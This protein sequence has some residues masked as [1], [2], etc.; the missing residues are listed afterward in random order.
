VPV[1]YDGAG[2]AAVCDLQKEGSGMIQVRRYGCCDKIFAGCQEPHC[3]TSKN[4][5]RDQREDVLA[6]HRIEMI[7]SKDFKLEECTCEYDENQLDLF[8][9]K[10]T[11]Q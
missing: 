1:L 10:T 4:W 7:D 3:Y 5:L 9:P 11:T 8:E 2:V 6:G